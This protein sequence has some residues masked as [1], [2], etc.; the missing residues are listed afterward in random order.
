[1][2]VGDEE[3]PR[4]NGLLIIAANNTKSA[5]EGE[6]AM[7]GRTESLDESLHLGRCERLPVTLVVRALLCARPIR[8][9]G[10]LHQKRVSFH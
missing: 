3:S 2:S 4:G 1:M 6:S 8:S 10:V 9:V 5:K 7:R